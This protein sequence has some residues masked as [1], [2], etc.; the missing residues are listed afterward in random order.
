MTSAFE[1][2]RSP[3]SQSRSLSASEEVL[4]FD[5]FELRQTIGESGDDSLYAAP[6]SSLRLP[7]PPPLAPSEDPSEA[8]RR[9]FASLLGMGA[10]VATGLALLVG[11]VWA[12]RHLLLSLRG[13]E[14][15]AT[16]VVPAGERAVRLDLQ[17]ELEPADP[18]DNAALITTTLPAGRSDVYVIKGGFVSR[19]HDYDFGA[20]GDDLTCVFVFETVVSRTIE[21][22]FGR[23]LVELRKIEHMRGAKLLLRG[24][25]AD[26]RPRHAQRF[27]A[28]RPR[29]PVARR[30][31]SAD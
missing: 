6:D 20:D 11:F 10:V 17:A 1:R 9:E 8:K 31:R 22:S 28:R 19:V 5:E 18:I 14:S 26:A 15:Y 24:G 25:R 2:P 27:A 21:Q 29:R 12:G 7:L 16:T 3:S 30:D 4:L 23:E 13:P